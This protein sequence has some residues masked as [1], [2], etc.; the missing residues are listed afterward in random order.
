ML[1]EQGRL[2][3]LHINHGPTEINTTE[4]AAFL[5]SA[6]FFKDNLLDKN[7]FFSLKGE[8]KIIKKQTTPHR[9]QRTPGGLSVW[10]PEAFFQAAKLS[11]SL[12]KQTEKKPTQM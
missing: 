8:K 6:V 9:P 2:L 3:V 7:T 12:A 4:P 10:Q 11:L 5:P 1:Q